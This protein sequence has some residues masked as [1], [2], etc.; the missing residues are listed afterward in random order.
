MDFKLSFSKKL[1][2]KG[3]DSFNNKRYN[4]ALHYFKES[5]LLNKYQKDCFEKI[6]KCK[7]ILE[8]FQ[9]KINKEKSKN[10]MIEMNDNCLNIINSDDYY[11]VLDLSKS[12]QTNQNF[13]VKQYKKQCKKYHPDNNFSLLAEDAF[14]KIFLAFLTL[15]NEDDRKIYDKYGGEQKYRENYY[16]ETKKKYKEENFDPYEVFEILKNDEN[17]EEYL[18]KKLADNERLEIVNLFNPTLVKIVK[19]IYYLVILGVI[20]YFV[21]PKLSQNTLYAFENSV[22]YPYKKVSRHHKIEY[23][24]GGAFLERYVGTEDI[25]NIEKEVEKDYL[26]FLEEECKSVNETLNKLEYKSKFYRKDSIYYNGVIENI[27][28]LN[29]TSCVK[30]EKF[31]KK[32]K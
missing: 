12:G 13:I 10:E 30:Y 27:K 20:C 23:Y 28:N 3:L 14:Y 1:Y 4:E 18:K 11:F 17:L 2:E 6:N 16:N 5:V 7:E 9:F 32:L 26:N 22:D 31:K 24:V 29:L 8:E 25:K 15:Y 21:L 19:L